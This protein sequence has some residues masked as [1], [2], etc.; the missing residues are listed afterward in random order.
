LLGGDRKLLLIGGSFFTGALGL[1]CFLSFLFPKPLMFYFGRQMMA[2]R[3][4]AKLAAYN[5]KWNFPHVRFVHRLI[6]LVWGC[7]LISQFLIQVVLVYTFPPAVVR[8]VAPTITTVI[9]VGTILW[10]FAYVRATRSKAEARSRQ[11]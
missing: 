1:A 6:T 11:M 4:T 3:D 7:S 8:A 10:T 9:L 5:Q 2:G